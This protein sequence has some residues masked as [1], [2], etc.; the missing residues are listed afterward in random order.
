MVSS[1]GLTVRSALFA[2]LLS[3]LAVAEPIRLYGKSVSAAT[4][5]G[6]AS[7]PTASANITSAASQA[8]G[9]ESIQSGSLP[10]VPSGASSAVLTQTGEATG[11]S[12]DST[13]QQLFQCGSQFYSK[14][15]VRTFPYAMLYTYTDYLMN[16]TF[17][18][19]TCFAQS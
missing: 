8:A 1:S 17:V 9:D 7:T 6:A 13:N 3:N 5:T 15:K 14:D 19:T 2:I 18:T 16:S 12:E 10:S 4:A 11:P